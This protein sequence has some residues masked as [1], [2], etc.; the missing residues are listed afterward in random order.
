M[1][2]QDNVVTQHAVAW[3]IGLYI[4][5][6]FLQIWLSAN[7]HPLAT[8]PSHGRLG[9]IKASMYFLWKMSSQ[10][11]HLFILVFM[12]RYSW[13]R[14][15][16]STNCPLLR[17]WSGFVALI[18]RGESNSIP[19]TERAW[20]ALLSWTYSHRW[21]HHCQTCDLPAF[22]LHHSGAGW[23]SKALSLSLCHLNQTSLRDS[24]WDS[25]EHSDKKGAQVVRLLSKAT[26]LVCAQMSGQHVRMETET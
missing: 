3:Y 16:E 15:K 19:P 26:Q 9:R 2:L 21:L 14:S 7:S 24:L 18:D 4:M 17:T 23:V 12:L 22:L 10:L 1:L 6:H 13:T 5:P 11:S 25:G 8:P 20:P